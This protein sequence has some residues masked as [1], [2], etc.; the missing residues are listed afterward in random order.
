MNCDGGHCSETSSSMLIDPDSA[1]VRFD[2][3]FAAPR[4]SA[5]PRGLVQM[6]AFGQQTVRAGKP[7]VGDVLQAVDRGSVVHDQNSRAVVE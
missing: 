3:A 4:R 2:F 7:V 5:L 6:V 1:D